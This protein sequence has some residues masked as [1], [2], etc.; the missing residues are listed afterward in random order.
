MDDPKQLELNLAE[1][2]AARDEGID[3]VLEHAGK[4]FLD[5]VFALVAAKP[6]GTELTGEDIRVDCEAIGIHPSHHNA[7]GGATMRLV[8]SGVLQN[9]GRLTAMRTKK[10]HARKTPVYVRSE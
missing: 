4:S 3:L 1:A 8:K 2:Q 7:W 10:S 5:Q 6:I 9:T